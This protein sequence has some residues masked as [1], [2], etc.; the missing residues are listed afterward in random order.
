MP[1]SCSHPVIGDCNLHTRQLVVTAC[2]LHI[3]RVRFSG[4]QCLSSED[5]ELYSVSQPRLYCGAGGGQE[6]AVIGQ[7]I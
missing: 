7:Q 4:Y 2:M 1:V 5:F 3:Y 6:T